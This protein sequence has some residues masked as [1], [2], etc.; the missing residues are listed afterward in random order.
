[1]RPIIRNRLFLAYAAAGLLL[2]VLFLVTL[3]PP[4]L[5]RERIE[6]WAREQGVALRFEGFE[7]D[8]PTGF[9]F[10]DLVLA[11]HGKGERFYKITDGALH[12]DPVALLLGRLGLTSSGTFSEG[13]Y[14]ARLHSASLFSLS[15]VRSEI[16]LQDLVI[17]ETPALSGLLRTA[18]LS[19]TFE[20]SFNRDPDAGAGHKAK[21][22]IALRSVSLLPRDHGTAE[23]TLRNLNVEIPYL[24]QDGTITLSRSRFKGD[25]LEGTLSGTIRPAQVLGR[26]ALNLLLEA[27]IDAARVAPRLASF[28]PPNKPWRIA[29]SGELQAPVYSIE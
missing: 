23:I 7:T 26:S 9:G 29:V 1:M 28:I 21:G 11:P 12:F 3:A 10:Q 13:R 17:S 24:M 25:G 15:D 14:L 20:G 27:R 18:V 19:G 4:S 16:T 5:V 22:T 6:G 2:F 8:L